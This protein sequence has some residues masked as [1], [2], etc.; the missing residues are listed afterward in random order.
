[1]EG[2]NTKKNKKKHHQKNSRMWAPDVY[3]GAPLTVWFGCEKEL[4]CD[5]PKK[6]STTKKTQKKGS[7]AFLISLV[8]LV[9]GIQISF[10][11]WPGSTVWKGSRS[12]DQRYARENMYV[13]ILH[14]ID[15]VLLLITMLLSLGQ[16]SCSATRTLVVPD[17]FS[18]F[19]HIDYLAQIPPQGA[20]YFTCRGNHGKSNKWNACIRA[21]LRQ[22]CRHGNPGDHPIASFWE[23]VSKSR[24]GSHP[25]SP[26]SLAQANLFPW[27]QWSEIKARI[28]SSDDVEFDIKLNCNVASGHKT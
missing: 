23:S 25:A 6:Q 9:F 8:I 10:E 27:L 11:C 14:E 5:P 21:L 1:M 26:G 2:P 17:G 18:S 13:L 16:M 12:T 4:P 3:E 28:E 15:A 24:H 7:L 20:M 22:C 19:T